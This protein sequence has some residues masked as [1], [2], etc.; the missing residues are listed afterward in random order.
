MNSFLQRYN[1]GRRLGGAF[2]L[3]ILL[4]CALVAI[5]LLSMAR[6]RTELDSIVK[7]NVEKSRISNGMLDAN[8][9]I[10]IALGTLAMETREELN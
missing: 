3:L 6:T 5:G 10:L 7:V 1:V 9:S 2:G 4:S 8:S